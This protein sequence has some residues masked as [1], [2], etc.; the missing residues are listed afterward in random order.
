V[1]R[2][3]VLGAGVAGLA[4]AWELER[5]H[6]GV[7]VL[8]LEASSRVGGLVETERTAD[9][10]LLEHGPDALLTRK[11]VTRSLLDGLALE[12][13]LLRSSQGPRTTYV[14]RG[15]RLLPLPEGLVAFAPSA[16]WPIFRSP[17]LGVA[18]KLRLACEPWIGRGEPVGDESV[19]SFVSRRFGK[20]FLEA[21]VA[22]VLEG[23]YGAGAT[24]LSARALLPTLVQAEQEHGS[25][26]P[27]LLRSRAATGQS[28][29]PEA[30]FVT[31]RSGMDRVIAAM[32]GRM[33]ATIHTRTRVQRL[34]RAGRALDLHLAGAGTTRVDGVVLAIPAR[35]AARLLSSLDGELAAGLDALPHSDVQL[36]SFGFAR[37]E[38]AHALDGTGFVVG[39]AEGRTMRA[40]TWASQ[41]WPGRAPDGSLLLR[42]FMHAP[43]ADATELAEAARRDLRDIMGIE[44]EPTLTR[45]RTARAVLPRSTVGHAERRAWLAERCRG[46][47]NLRLAG[48]ALGTVG[49]PDCAHS[50]VEAA[51]ELSRQVQPRAVEGRP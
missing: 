9:G 44:A 39:S 32:R 38:V 16:L 3:A 45:V 6:P 40:C 21:I 17:L 15:D 33:R 46:L 5:D 28:A 8:V 20:A 1:T 13:E 49:V 12:G 2:I 47:S 29:P 19:L 51:R 22:P 10:Y 36:V 43:G 4:A 35:E 37:E 25:L 30:P 14:A 18:G 50:G 27:L 11:P 41:K 7:E 48:S 42:C 34:S 24:E 26:A 31:P 23:V